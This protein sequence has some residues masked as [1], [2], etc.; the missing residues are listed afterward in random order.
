MP[1]SYKPQ[2]QTDNSGTWYDNALRFA[3]EAEA[4]ESAEA[5]AG[6]WYSVLAYRAEP[7]D[8]PVKHKLESGRLVFVS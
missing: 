1:I 4:H 6:R 8:D 7:C 2:V 3:T 5:L